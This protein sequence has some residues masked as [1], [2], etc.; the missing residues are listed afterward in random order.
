MR[1]EACC[2]TVVTTRLKRAGMCWTPEGLDAILPLRT[3]ML[4]RT[5]DTFFIHPVRRVYEKGVDN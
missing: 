2:Q 4:N 5:S 1:I 3:S